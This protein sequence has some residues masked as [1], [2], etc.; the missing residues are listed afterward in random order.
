MGWEGFLAVIQVRRRTLR[1]G[2][3]GGEG[4]LGLKLDTF[5]L[6]NVRHDHGRGQEG[7]GFAPLS[8]NERRELTGCRY[9]VEIGLAEYL[10]YARVDL[11]RSAHLSLILLS[12][13]LGGSYLHKSLLTYVPTRSTCM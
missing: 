4:G 10:L 11:L 9:G 6:S 12:A 1:W 3:G 8:L 7:D 2:G 5:L 13:T